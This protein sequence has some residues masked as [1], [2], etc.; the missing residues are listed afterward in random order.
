MDKQS[1][2]SL[3]GK[4]IICTVGDNDALVETTVERVSPN[5]KYVFLGGQLCYD[6]I[7]GWVDATSVVV[8]DVIGVI[9]MTSRQVN[10][11]CRPGG[12]V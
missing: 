6:Q 8:V 2:V 12:G 10:E 9:G 1:V 7:I 11:V 3:F 5:G 4:R